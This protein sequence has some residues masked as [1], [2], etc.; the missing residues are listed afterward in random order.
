MKQK[1]PQ[2]T[3]LDK[4]LLQ[5][6]QKSFPLDENP[7]AVIADQLECSEEEVIQRYQY[8]LN[9]GFISRIGPVFNHKKMGVST[10]A[11]ISTSNI[12]VEQHAEIIN[13]FI[14]VNHNYLREHAYNLWF[15]VTANNE[16]RLKQVISSIE[17]Q[18]GC[19]VLSLPMERSF[20]IDLGFDLW[21]SQTN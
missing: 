19:E 20:H 9:E 17:Q 1:N 3:N 16:Y 4:Q 21:P 15:V 5:N 12:N 2:L 14:E 10:L 7:F 13:S 11:A 18:T 8:M 6:F